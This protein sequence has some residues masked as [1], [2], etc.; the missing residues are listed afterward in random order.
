[1]KNSLLVFIPTYN[2][3]ENVERLY[4]DLQSLNLPIDILFM[5]DNSPDGTGKILDDLA[6]K[7]TNL[8]VVHRRGKL[9]IGSAHFEGINWAYDQGYKQLITMDCDF[10]HPPVYIHDLLKV[11][12]NYDIVVTSRYMQ[13]DSLEDWG[14]F[15]KFLTQL[16]HFLTKN[17]LQLHYD[18]TGGFRLYDLEKIPQGLFGLVQSKSYS[19]LFESLFI[20]NFNKHTITEIPIKLPKR[21]Y[22]HSKM[23]LSDAMFSFRYLL[24]L[25]FHQMFNP[26]KFK[27]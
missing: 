20:L 11:G 22:G 15:R 1:M 2:E 10:T 8:F 26:K 16:G 25:F 13:K 14:L 12:K 18:A 4:H 23:R 5:D 24:S 27:I 21:T 17:L 3:K 19:F 9:G 6:A 7:N